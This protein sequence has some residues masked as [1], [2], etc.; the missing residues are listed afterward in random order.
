MKNEYFNIR[1]LANN[2]AI[3][4]FGFKF[5]ERRIDHLPQ[6]KIIAQRFHEELHSWDA[7]RLGGWIN[8]Y[9]DWFSG[10]FSGIRKG[11]SIAESYHTI[12]LEEK[13]HDSAEL[14]AYDYL[15]NYSH[16]SPSQY[17]EMKR[18]EW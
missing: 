8:F 16:L 17:M 15:V 4:L 7:E 3:N 6:E 10:L 13:V 14:M 2:S 11:K 5:F 18:E 1:I 12:E 9:S